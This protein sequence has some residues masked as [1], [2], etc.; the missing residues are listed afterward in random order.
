MKN[1]IGAV[2]DNRRWLALGVIVA[3]QFMVVLDIAIVNVALPS[4]KT[5]LNFSQASLQWV[6]SAYAIVFGGF[7]LLGGRLGDVLGR[8]RVFMVGLTLFT[9]SSLLCGVSWSEQ[10]RGSAAD[11]SPPPR[12]RS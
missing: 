4:I 9:V 7:L 3:A 12:S 10:S 5:D 6:I 1:S 8:R 2:P 11:Y